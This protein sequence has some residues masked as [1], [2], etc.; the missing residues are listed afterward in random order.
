MSEVL[1]VE[2]YLFEEESI[3]HLSLVSIELETDFESANDENWRDYALCKGLTKIFYDSEDETVA[4][5]QKREEYAKKICNQCPVKRSCLEDAYALGEFCVRGGTTASE[6]FI[7]TRDNR[8]KVAPGVR[9]IL[10]LEKENK[11]SE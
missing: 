9:N 11:A 3:N 7:E 2:A 8:L 4:Q 10:R 5:R 1:R 6:R